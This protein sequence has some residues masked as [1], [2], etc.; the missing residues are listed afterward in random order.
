MERKESGHDIC[1]VGGLGH[2]GLPLGIAFARAGRKVVLYDIDK[3]ATELVLGGKLPFKEAGGEEAL[4]PV[5]GKTLFVSNDK[6]SISDSRFVIIVIGTPVDEHLNPKFTIFKKFFDEIALNVRDGQ[7][8][9]LRSTVYPGTTEL[10]EKLLREAGK[11]VRVS[12]CPERIAQGNALEELKT[13]PQIVSSFD[14]EARAEAGALFGDIAAEIIRL[15][16]P[17]AELAKLFTNVWRYMQ[18]AISNQF[19]QVA[20]QYGLDF[21]RIYDAITYKYPRAKSFPSAGF[22]AGPCLFKDTMQLAAFNNNNFFMGHAA[23]LINEGLPN[24]IVQRIKE[25]HGLKDKTVGVLGMAFKANND[26]K[27][28]SLSY[29]L[30]KILEVEAKEV[31]CSDVYIKEDGFV[32]VDELLRRSDI[33]ILGTPHSEYK[34]LE[35]SGRM[36][37]DIWNFFGRGGLF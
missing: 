25:R 11:K 3:R 33:V 31:V 28:E 37:V 14:E 2:V 20:T 5:L 19:Y 10:V 6:G 27:R 26:D 7:H 13:L 24:F 34:G 22:A 30:K 29:K 17:E 23:M 32:S 18:F 8:I 1:I 16:P 4:K 15:S 21:Y 36:L 35:I 9:I 12:Y